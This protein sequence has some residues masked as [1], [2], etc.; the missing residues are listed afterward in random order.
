MPGFKYK[1]FKELGLIGLEGTQMVMENGALIG[2]Y[3]EEFYKDEIAFLEHMKRFQ[4]NINSDI[5]TCR[6]FAA[7][8]LIVV[9]RLFT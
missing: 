2:C 9:Y 3:S 1:D 4:Q 8:H 6:W 5:I 7:G